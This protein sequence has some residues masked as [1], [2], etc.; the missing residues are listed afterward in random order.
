MTPPQPVND[1]EGRGAC[2][3][4]VLFA[5][6]GDDTRRGLRS[7]GLRPR[8]LANSWRSFGSLMQVHR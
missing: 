6:G 4:V 7:G 3:A 8:S 5:R 1:G 2:A